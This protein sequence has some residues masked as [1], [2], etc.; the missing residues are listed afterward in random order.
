[1]RIVYWYQILIA[2]STLGL[3]DSAPADWRSETQAW[4]REREA[5]LTKPDGY[6]AVAGLYFLQPGENSVGAKAGATVV[7]PA[8]APAAAG[9]FLYENGSVRYEPAAGVNATLNDQ[10][11][12]GVVT[13]LPAD[14]KAK[15]PADRLGIGTLS[16]LLHRSGARLGVRLRDPDSPY[17]RH[18]GGLQWFALDPAWRLPGRFVTYDTPKTVQI[19]NILGD[20]EDVSSPGEVEVRVKGVTMR[21]ATVQA[22]RGRLWIIFSDASA[23]K[24]TYRIRFLYIDA[25]DANH[26]VDVD[27]NRAYNAPC[28]FNP[29]TTCPLPPRQNRLTVAVRAGERKY[30]GPKS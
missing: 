7:L 15:R 27:F 29:H 24:E 14:P 25:P 3:A 16:L 1:M 30:A 2:C 8:G 20:V 4:R 19:E 23:E 6:L 28:A 17:R 22:S 9:R 13:L 18:F 12:A 21:L 5:E 11:I 26:A 10:P